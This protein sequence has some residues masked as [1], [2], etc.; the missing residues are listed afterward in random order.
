MREDA[1]CHEQLKPVGPKLQSQAPYSLHN[2]TGSMLCRV[3][4]FATL[5]TGSSVYGI[6]QARILEQVAIASSRA[7]SQPGD[8]TQASCIS[9]AG[10]QILYLCATWEVPQQ[11]KPPQWDAQHHKEEKPLLTTTRESSRS[12]KDPAQPNINKIKKKK[13]KITSYVY[14]KDGNTVTTG[15]SLAET[16][17]SQCRGPRFDPW[18]GN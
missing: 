17:C 5:R 13:T 10:R 6:I 16:L 2:K 4:L 7:S 1:T 11:Q 9:G 8:W 18:L 3:Q 15:T 14:S 12:N